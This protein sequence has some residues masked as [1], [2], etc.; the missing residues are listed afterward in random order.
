[1]IE[2][3]ILFLLISV[4]LVRL[5]FY[6]GRMYGYLMILFLIFV[7]LPVWYFIKKFYLDD[8]NYDYMIYQ[9]MNNNYDL[10]EL[11]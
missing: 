3:I 5:F 10:N 6:I 1:M 8:S 2:N 11:D 9:Q 7:V 4:I